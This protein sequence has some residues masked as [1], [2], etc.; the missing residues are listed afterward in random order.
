MKFERN[1]ILNLPQQNN[2]LQR[3]YKTSNEA[4]R[5]C[6]FMERKNEKKEHEMEGILKNI[7]KNWYEEK[8]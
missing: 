5:F 6:L 7:N 8:L 3:L 2:Y 1:K 4:E